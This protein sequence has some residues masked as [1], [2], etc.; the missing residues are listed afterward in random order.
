MVE[1][2][3]LT[4]AGISHESGI[5]TFRDS[6]GLW[7]NH[8][9]EDVATP[10]AFN[11]N[12]E[13]V[14]RFYNQR[15]RALQSVSPNAAHLALVKLEQFMEDKF[16]LVTQNVDDLH[17]RAGS[18]RLIHMHGELLK[19]LCL[20]CSRSNF[21]KNDFDATT[22]CSSCLAVGCLRPDIVWFEEMPRDMDRI[23][24]ALSTCKTFLSI[25][26]S[27]W[28]YPAAGFVRE[29]SPKARTIEINI[30]STQISDAFKEHRTGPAT[31]ELPLLIDQ[32][33]AELR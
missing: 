12:P 28:V 29:L 31:R 2:V 33:L 10:G 23:Y 19:A 18:R 16:L 14:Y 11:R 30:D 22:K 25:G 17:D 3:V 4:G 8:R 27:G 21:V 5:K 13:L 15:R 7:E 24:D 26:T 6:D 20:K 32:L 9:I 1:L